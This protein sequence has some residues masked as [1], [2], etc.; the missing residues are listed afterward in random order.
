[1]NRFASRA[2]LFTV[3]ALLCG[4]A[5]A[6]L[7]P[8]QSAMPLERQLMDPQYR[9]FYDALEGE[10]DWTLIEPYGYV[11]RPH[12]NFVAWTPYEYGFWV[13][14]D[15]YGWVWISTEPFG[16]ATY[17][18]G[19]WM[20]DSFQGWV[21]IPGLDWGPAWVT[22]ETTSNY[23]GWAPLMPRGVDPRS[24]PGDSQI[25]APFSALGATDLAN[26]VVPK[27]QLGSQLA[28]A[29]PANNVIERNGVTINRGP[30]IE[31]VERI[32]GTLPR[33]KL[34]EVGATAA[35]RGV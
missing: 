17:H 15:V 23:V 20:Y 22:W 26:H 1:M 21:W 7:Q 19:Q 11:F 34:A 8:T 16:W 14:S 27:E 6:G 13:P 3:L 30:A 24:I 12:V 2:L 33:V 4:C 9:V 32:T 28:E 10:G 25:W 18:Y 5:A 35:A 31:R 29:R